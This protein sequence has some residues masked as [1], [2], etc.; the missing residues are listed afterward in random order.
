VELCFPMRSLAIICP[1]HN[2]EASINY[3]Y[4]QVVS[5]M[6]A[7]SIEVSF[8]FF[9]INNASTDSTLEKIIDLRSKD[10]RVQVISQSRNFGYQSSVLCGVHQASAEA[11]VV[12][13]VDCEDPP[14]LV[15][16]FIKYWLEGYDIAYGVRV[17]RPEPSW[18]Q[19]MRK[20]FY[21]L[22]Y[23]IADWD[24]II[25]M[26]E[27]SLFTDRVKKQIIRSRSTF[28]FVRADLAFVGFRRIGIPYSRE[29]RRFGES[30]YNLLR[31]IK[32]AISGILSSSTFPLR[33]IA[34]FGIPIVLLNVLMSLAALF[35]KGGADWLLPLN[36]AFI[37]TS[38]MFLAM[39]V[40][41]I[42]KDVMA[43]P[44]FIVDWQNSH[45]NRSDPNRTLE[46]Q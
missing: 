1:V 24:F 35:G 30:H 43:R 4:D 9:F 28:P 3:F 46:Q 17:G 19:G 37:S 18:L 10:S 2:E 42:Y 39:Y 38:L 5:A 20:L 44:L 13:D 8:E 15:P 27:F 45:V 26:A 34:Y 16:V 7:T 40:A 31:M 12:I 23:A 41:R 11:Y 33:A 14:S 36:A 21:R 29:R 22:T 6:E 32:F 25:D